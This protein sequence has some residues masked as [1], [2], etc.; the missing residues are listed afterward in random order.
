M[1]EHKFTVSSRNRSVIYSAPSENFYSFS[2]S[3][4]ERNKII[5]AF[6]NFQSRN[7]WGGEKVC[8]FLKS[9]QKRRRKK[10]LCCRPHFDKDI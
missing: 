7:C 5:L 4:N 8:S 1:T 10:Y 6:Q 9:R 3:G 2:S